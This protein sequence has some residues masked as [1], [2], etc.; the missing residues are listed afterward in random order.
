MNYIIS[1]VTQRLFHT[2]L[3][4]FYSNLAKSHKELESFL[5]LMD[6]HHA[7]RIIHHDIQDQLQ[8]YN[9]LDFFH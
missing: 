3:Q 4:L 8:K 2:Y 1:F 6:N 9:L 7:F 5:E